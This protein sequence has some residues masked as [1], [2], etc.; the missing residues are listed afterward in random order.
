MGDVSKEKEKK[1]N[2]HTFLHIWGG[3]FGG[4]V[5]FGKRGEGGAGSQ[6]HTRNP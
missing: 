4:G 1:G 5:F 3:G 2:Y 6:E